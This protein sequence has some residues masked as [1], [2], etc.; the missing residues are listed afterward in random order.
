MTNGGGAGARG[1]AEDSVLR[2]IF[3]GTARSTGKAF[4]D[5][6]V[7]HLALA[8]GT[9]CAWVTEWL[10]KPRRLRALSFWANGRHVPD[11]EYDIAGTPCE[12]VIET[13]ALVFV[14]DRVIELY[15]RDTDLPPLGAVSYMGM[16]LCDSDGSILGHLAL[17]D[18]KP[19]CES[20]TANAVFSIFGARAG[21]ELA[22]LR[23]DRALR[24]RE[25]KLTQLFDSAM[26]AIV[27]LDG[28]LAVM[29]VNPAAE[30]TFGRRAAEIEGRSAAVLFSPPV[31]GRLIHVARE[32]PRRPLAERSLWITDGL[33]GVRPGGDTFAAEA[34]LSAFELNG[35]PCFTLILRNIDDR[36]DAERRIRTL[37]VEAA[38]L[39]AEIEALA[40]FEEIVGESEALLR[41]L[42]DVERVAGSDTTVLITGETG[43]GKELVA[44]AI[45]R[46]SPRSGKPLVKVNCAAIAA[47]L[48]ESEFFGHEKGAFTGATQRRDGRF[49][50]AD[51]GT[52]FLDEVGEMPLDLQAKLLRVLQEGEFERVGGARTEKVDVRVVAATNRDLDRMVES[53]T[54]RRDLLYRLNV[55]PV[56]VPP[57]RERGGDVVL[58]AQAFARR[59]AR[60][61]GVEVAPLGEGARQRLRRYDWP[62]NVRELENVVERALITSRDG[63]TLN[64]DRALPD[65]APAAPPAPGDGSAAGRVL[66]A[67]ELGELERANI[68]RALESCGGKISGAGG[69]AEVL[70]LHPNTLASRMRSLG[71]KR[72]R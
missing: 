67:A 48:Q 35:R 36:L 54:F 44:R 7:R 11:Y 26:D 21:A 62:G 45:H 61:R 59:L 9:T 53:G 6:L 71:L 25:Q 56:H 24:E 69:A 27:E 8:M 40:G 51:G 19:M 17:L 39:R 18:D 4:F 46:R 47:T 29:S 55:F 63:R 31:F 34:T 16:P 65:A 5:D 10:E 50:L 43:T 28:S 15:P 58:L 14:R 20:A 33:E 22:R 30:R 60:Q 32:L 23:R 38:E 1:L 49:K 3:A 57:L 42:A 52:I 37:T 70:G 66:T 41:M 68:I 12:T 64:L 13:P 2:E 72:P